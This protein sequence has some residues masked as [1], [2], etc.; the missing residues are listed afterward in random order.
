MIRH[1]V[2]FKLKE[3]ETDAEKTASMRQIKEGLEALKNKIDVIRHIQVDFNC[4][5]EETWDIILTSE[6][7]SLDDLKAYAIHPE[8][9]AV[10]KQA[11]APVKADRA[12]VD[13]E[14]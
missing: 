11:I 8:H 12:C 6:F 7:D 13:Y 5:P 4:N 1:I 14:F 10:G 2:M 9:Q 3:F